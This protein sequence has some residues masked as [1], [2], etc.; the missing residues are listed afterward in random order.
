MLKLIPINE[1]NGKTC[2]VCGETRSVKYTADIYDENN[3]IVKQVPMC[4]LCA[5]E[6]NLR[7]GTA[8]ERA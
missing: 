5:L 3:E 2:A 8:N 7:K 1:R 4:N 6:L